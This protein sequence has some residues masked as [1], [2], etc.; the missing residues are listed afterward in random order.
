MSLWDQRKRL[1]TSC[2][3]Q[4]PKNIQFTMIWN[5]SLRCWK[6]HFF[7]LVVWSVSTNRC[8]SVTDS[9]SIILTMNLLVYKMSENSKNISNIISK[10]PNWRLQMSCF[11]RPT[12]QN[13]RVFSLLSHRTKKSSKSTQLRS[14]NWWTF[15]FFA[16]KKNDSND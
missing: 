9:S 12:V 6:Q 8:I 13:P 5:K 4:K 3:V 11:V 16:W 7:G 2:F 15:Y 1:Q 14:W 10:S